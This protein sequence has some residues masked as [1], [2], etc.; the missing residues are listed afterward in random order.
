MYNL[1]SLLHEVSAAHVILLTEFIESLHPL[2]LRSEAEPKI[3]GE[4]VC[5]KLLV[6]ELSLSWLPTIG[7]REVTKVQMTIQAL[8]TLVL[9]LGERVADTFVLSM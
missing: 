8:S 4:E 2:A 5:F 3:A 9:Y 7:A 1:R 6:G